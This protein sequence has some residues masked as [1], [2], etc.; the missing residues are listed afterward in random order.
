MYQA[1]LTSDLDILQDGDMTEVG[2]K[3]VNLSGGQKARVNLAR[4]LYS[5]ARTVYMDDILSAVDAHTSKFLVKECLGGKL[6]QG[7]TVV[8]VSHHVGLCLPISDFVVSLNNG[9][10][11]QA[12]SASEVNLNV[13]VAQLPEDEQK[14][15]DEE[16]EVTP[17]KPFRAEEEQQEK[18]SSRQVY[19]TEHMATGRV[20]WADYAFVLGAAGGW[21]YWV[22]LV[23][24]YVF[25]RGMDIGQAWWLEHWTSDPDQNDLDLNLGVYALL[26]T[27]G[28]MTGALRW[29]WL[30]GV[31]NIGFYNRGSRRIHNR[32]LSVIC[33][34]P[35]SFFESTP[36]GRLLNI[37][38][39]DMNRLD[40]WSADAFGSEC[41][42]TY[43]F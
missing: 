20:E 5:R 11:D 32:L 9:V 17:D 36:S 28:V 41:S 19:K 16:E 25:V 10:V 3:G 26:V 23:L 2:A 15:E 33:D 30:Y 29:V 35:L 4:C 14:E 42:A 12:G 39:Q 22:I 37:F 7:R 8:L 27:G 18:K 1:A 21:W 40:G 38:G 34:A 31:G 24:M 43:I 13:I 6:L